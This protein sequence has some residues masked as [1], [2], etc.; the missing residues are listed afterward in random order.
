MQHC[1]VFL[2]NY[3]LITTFLFWKPLSAMCIHLY[4]LFFFQLWLGWSN[5]KCKAVQ[6]SAAA[7]V[8]T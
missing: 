8:E 3:R 5:S 4:I 2:W 6:H 1:A 7:M